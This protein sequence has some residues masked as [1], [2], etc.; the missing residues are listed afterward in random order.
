MRTTVIIGLL[1]ALGLGLLR[2][3]RREPDYLADFMVN[4]HDDGSV[5]WSLVIPNTTW[6]ELKAK[7]NDDNSRIAGSSGMGD[8]VLKL[9]GIGFGKHGYNA[10]RCQVVAKSLGLDGSV[11]YDG[12]CVWTDAPR[13]QR[14]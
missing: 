3:S 1:V 13:G 4:V 11:K 8:E 12:Q 10:D 5:A 14:I 2:W 9:V 7:V 6:Q